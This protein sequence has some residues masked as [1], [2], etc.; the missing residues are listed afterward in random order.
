MLLLS[1]C[2]LSL[3]V[4]ATRSLSLLLSASILVHNF[5]LIRFTTQVVLSR[6]NAIKGRLHSMHHSIIVAKMAIAERHL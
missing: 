4:S 2:L 3:L 1:L 6:M 5:P